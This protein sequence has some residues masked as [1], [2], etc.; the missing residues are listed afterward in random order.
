[1]KP[2]GRFDSDLGMF[3]DEPRTPSTAH[4]EFLKYLIAQGRL[5]SPRAPAPPRWGQRLTALA[6]R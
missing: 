2:L 1:M 3:V 4:L 5:E 6:V